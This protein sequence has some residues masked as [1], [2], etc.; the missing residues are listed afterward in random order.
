MSPLSFLSGWQ[1]GV[2]RVYGQAGLLAGH[3]SSAMAHLSVLRGA[4]RRQP[5]G[6]DQ[7][8]VTFCVWDDP[9]GFEC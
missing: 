3:G 9:L 6:H 1:L 2:A 4:L 5:Q 7:I 8:E